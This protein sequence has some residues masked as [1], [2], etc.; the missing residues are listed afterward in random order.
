MSEIK[1]DVLPRVSLRMLTA[2][3]GRR[4]SKVYWGAWAIYLPGLQT[5]LLHSVGGLVH[6]IYYKAPKREAVLAGQMNRPSKVPLEI[7]QAALTKPITRRVAENY[8]CMQRLHAAGLGPAPLSLVVAPNYRALFS[9]GPTFSAGYRVE[10]I[11]KLPEKEPATEAQMRAAGVIPDG[12]LASI[13]EQIRGYVSDLNSAR[14]VMPD[15]GEDEVAAIE[16][17]LNEALA[18]ARD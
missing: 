11:F 17:Q 13:R 4:W 10:N 8:V 14:G 1:V 16:L 5:K 2:S 15:G 6:C 12:S 3:I 9:R 7:W 18:R